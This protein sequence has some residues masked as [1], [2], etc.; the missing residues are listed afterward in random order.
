[1]QVATTYNQIQSPRGYG[2]SIE[3]KLKTKGLIIKT[4]FFINL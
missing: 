4:T 2:S 1:M 3:L